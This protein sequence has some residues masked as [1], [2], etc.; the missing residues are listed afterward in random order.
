VPTLAE[1]LRERGW[2]T[3]AILANYFFLDP[4]FGLDRGFEHYD[5]RPGGSVRGHFPLSQM[6]GQAQRAGHLSYRDAGAITDLALEWLRAPS[7]GRPTFLVVNYCDAHK[8]TL[9]PPPFDRAF[10]RRASE[11]LLQRASDH[12]LQYDQSLLYLDSQLGRL[13]GAVGDRTLVIVTSD[14]GESLGDHDLWVHGWTLYEGVV[15]VPLFVAPPQGPSAPVRREPVTS[16]DV[17]DIALAGLGLTE[18]WQPASDP[19]LSEWFQALDVPEQLRWRRFDRDLL[20]WLQG[21]WKVIV[22]STGQVEAYDLAGDPGEARPLVLDDARAEAARARA[23]AWW[24]ER[25]PRA[26]EHV[27]LQA[28]DLERMRE[29]GYLGDTAD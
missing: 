13:L 12:S 9:P 5:A 27:E 6:A 21:D 11:P 16:A 26:P 10:G 29:L 28:A 15:R 22:S 4:R 7:D 1:V 23:R 25:P 2:R 24:A 19:V 8:P 20:S 14:H 3:G 18:P 17:F